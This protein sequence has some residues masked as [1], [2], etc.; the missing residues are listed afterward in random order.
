M[1]PPRDSGDDIELASCAQGA[2]LPGRA[3]SCSCEF[4][5]DGE[6]SHWGGREGGLLLLALLLGGQILLG[7]KAGSLKQALRSLCLPLLR[8]DAHT[9]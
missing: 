7:T 4:L 1:L 6:K 9:C 8:G 3:S 2:C 5:A